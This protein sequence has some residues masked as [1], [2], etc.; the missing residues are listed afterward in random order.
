[1]LITVGLLGTYAHAAFEHP[2]QRLLGR[3]GIAI[4]KD[5]TRLEGNPTMIP[6][7]TGGIKKLTMELPDGTKRT[8]T[9]GELTSFAFKPTDNAAPGHDYAYYVPVLLPSGKPLLVQQLNRGFFTL[10]LNSST[11]FNRKRAAFSGGRRRN[12]P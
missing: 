5:G 2:L 11:N 9:P 1:M 6:K 10:L 12:T 4:L 3:E 7:G 8:L